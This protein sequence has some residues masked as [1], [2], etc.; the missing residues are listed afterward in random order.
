MSLVDLVI[1][2]LVGFFVGIGAA[3]L[4]LRWKMKR[5][6]G[7]MQGHMEDMFD[8]TDELSSG[9]GSGDIDLGDDEFDVEDVQD[10][11]EEK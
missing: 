8:L 1:G 11:K 7:M 3:V 2:G 10:E 5:Q 4:Y 9:M 6:L